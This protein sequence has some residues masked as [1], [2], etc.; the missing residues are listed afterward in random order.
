MALSF[1][2]KEHECLGLTR[3]LVYLPPG[4]YLRIFCFLLFNN[5]RVV[6]EYFWLVNLVWA[7][8]YCEY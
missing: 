7:I 2:K 1:K 4:S 6:H 5:A 8:N 3:R